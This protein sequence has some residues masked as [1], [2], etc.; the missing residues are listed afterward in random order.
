M[1]NAI[2]LFKFEGEKVSGLN[3]RL[4]RHSESLENL[5]EE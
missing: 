5:R 3:S 1:H 4:Y 2:G